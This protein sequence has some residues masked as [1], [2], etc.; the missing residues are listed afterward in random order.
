MN[1]IV[2]TKPGGLTSTEVG[3]IRKP[4]IHLMPI[5]GVE[6]YNAKFFEKNG[7]SIVSNN[8]EEVLNNTTKLLKDKELQK[9]MI[10]NQAKIINRNSAKDL[11]NFILKNL[12]GFSY[13]K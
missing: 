8:I 12:G 1:I 2:L 10:E 6:N 5:P 11:V 13:E 9:Q 7:L 4:I 3:I